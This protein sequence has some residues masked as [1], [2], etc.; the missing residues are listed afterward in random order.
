MNQHEKRVEITKLLTFIYHEWG[1]AVTR[2]DIEFWMVQLQGVSRG[3]AWKAAKELV[4]RKTYGSPKFQDFWSVLTEIAPR[5]L[6]YNGR[7]EST[8]EIV[9]G[10]KTLPVEFKKHQLLLG[11]K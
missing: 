7:M 2:E 11:E 3:L 9:L 6:R 8:E 5:R 1:K 4:R 10:N